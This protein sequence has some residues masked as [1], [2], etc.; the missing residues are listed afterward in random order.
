MT[1]AQLRK[2]YYNS[3]PF[4][5]RYLV[6]LF[7]VRVILSRKHDDRSEFVIDWKRCCTDNLPDVWWA[8]LKA[9]T[10]IHQYNLIKALKQTLW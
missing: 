9:H 2:C 8:S 6:Y 3:V 1:H 5:F 10:P 7:A 4:T